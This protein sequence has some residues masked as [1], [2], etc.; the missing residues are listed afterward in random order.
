MRRY[1]EM[2]GEQVVR[3]ARAAIELFLRS[4]NVG[5]RIIVESLKGYGS[6]NGVFVTI[7]HYPTRSMRGRA[8]IY[9]TGKRM[10]ELV[11]DAATGAAFM[12]PR[13]VPVSLAEVGHMTVEV[14]IL[15]DFEEIRSSG[16]G[17]MIKVRLGRDG[18]CIRYGVKSAILLPSFPKE[19]GLGKAGFFEEACRQIGIQKDLW[20]QPRVRLFR[21]ETQRFAEEEPDGRVRETK[22]GK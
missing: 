19:H 18:L 12:D 20:M 22:G 16:R 14:D 13:A 1:S 7:S 11:V 17:K 6:P 9:G 2:E 5:R 8:G 15:S 3:T 21:F 4:P 10:G